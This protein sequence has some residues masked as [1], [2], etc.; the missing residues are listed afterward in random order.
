MLVNVYAQMMYHVRPWFG[1]IKLSSPKF[2]ISPPGVS[3]RIYGTCLKISGI[4]NIT[5]SYDQE[6]NPN[7]VAG[8]DFIRHQ[9]LL[10]TKK[11]MNNLSKVFNTDVHLRPFRDMLFAALVKSLSFISGS[12]SLIIAALLFRR[13]ICSS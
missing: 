5:I 9:L 13:K 8:F 10:K 4:S 11:N 12:C 2:E 3:S 7:S 6:R 1:K